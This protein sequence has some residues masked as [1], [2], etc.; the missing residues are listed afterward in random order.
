MRR[1]C[2]TLRGFLPVPVAEL[3]REFGDGASADEVCARSIRALRAAGVRHFYVSNL[4]L[5]RAATTLQ[6]VMS[7]AGPSAD[8]ERGEVRLSRTCA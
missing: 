1:R 5:G 4:P 7:L 3:T 8:G 2:S 6:R